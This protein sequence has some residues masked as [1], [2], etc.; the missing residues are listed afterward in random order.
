M[1]N[2]FAAEIESWVTNSVDLMEGVLH[3]STQQTIEIMQTPG[4]SKASTKMAIEKGAGLGK[5]GRNSKK[6]YGP[7]NMQSGAGRLPVDTGFLWHSLVISLNGMPPLRDNPSGDTTYTY[8]P[9]PINLAINNA[10]L[11][12]TIHAGYSSRYAAKVNYSYG[13]MF[14]DMATQQWPQTVAKVVQEL[15]GRTGGG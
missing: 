4:P 15:K 5:N 6:A 2:N 11:G 3:E 1:T 9:D 8:N 10:A 12:Q 13:Y 14:V 7:V